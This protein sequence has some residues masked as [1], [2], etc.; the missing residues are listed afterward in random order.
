MTGCARAGCCHALP[1][2]GSSASMRRKS[3]TTSNSTRPWRSSSRYT[4]RCRAAA[5]AMPISSVASNTARCSTSTCQKTETIEKQNSVEFAVRSA[6][7]D[8]PSSDGRDRDF[9]QALVPVDDDRAGPDCDEQ[10]DD[11]EAQHAEIGVQ[12]ADAIPELARQLQLIAQQ[13]QR[14]DA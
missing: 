12:R 7:A 9:F 2:A 13:P 1:S 5:P 10:R 6:C 3:P 4:A 8:G 14:L 11:R